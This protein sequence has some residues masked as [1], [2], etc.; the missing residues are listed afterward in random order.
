MT[1][2]G[3][4]SWSEL[5]FDS[6]IIMVAVAF[7]IIAALVVLGLITYYKKRSTTRRSASCTSLWR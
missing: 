6:S 7:E 5:P 2:L 3:K 4:L 1:L